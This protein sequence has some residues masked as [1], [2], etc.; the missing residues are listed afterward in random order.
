MVQYVSGLVV[1]FC[2][3]HQGSLK[4]LIWPGCYM[5]LKFDILQFKRYSLWLSWNF[6]C[7]NSIKPSAFNGAAVSATLSPFA[8]VSVPHLTSCFKD[9][10]GLPSLLIA[11]FESLE[12]RVRNSKSVFSISHV[13]ILKASKLTNSWVAAFVVFHVYWVS[14]GALETEV[15]CNDVRCVLLYQYR[16][17]LSPT[18]WLSISVCILSLIDHRLRIPSY[19]RNQQ[20]CSQ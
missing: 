10:P 8:H 18:V 6:G 2:I 7:Y 9:C 17:I 3:F 11:W 20:R 5:V 14:R 1:P 4:L 15:F 12:V 16:P 19:P 13:W